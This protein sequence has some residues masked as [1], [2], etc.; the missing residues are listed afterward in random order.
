MDGKD[1]RKH[2]HH[3]K[4]WL[5]IIFVIGI[6]GM[7]FYTN[8]L[9]FV[10]LGNFVQTVSPPEQYF[11]MQLES[12]EQTFYSKSFSISNTS[13]SAEGVCQQGAKINDISISKDGAVCKVNL[14]GLEGSF[15][16][17]A[18]GSLIING[19]VKSMKIDDSS[20]SSGKPLKVVI[21][22]VP[23]KFLLSDLSLKSINLPTASG[24]ISKLRG[25]GASV[26][27]MLNKEPVEISNFIGY[28]KLEDG[29]IF[30]TG[31]SSSVKSQEF[32]W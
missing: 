10:K 9:S 16:F 15:D 25:D 3:W 30:L 21:Q 1:G 12:D 26:I 24:K 7:L 14:N 31:E 28:L 23:T 4:L 19:N 13:L 17:T 8:A 29:K 6:V 2:H 32:K 27:G 22:V 11:P 18:G 20:Y 5:S